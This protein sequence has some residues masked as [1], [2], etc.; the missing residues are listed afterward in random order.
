MEIFLS[1][2]IL[3]EIPFVLIV[4]SLIT[5]IWNTLFLEGLVKYIFNIFLN[6]L[7]KIYIDKFFYMIKLF[8]QNGLYIFLS[9]LFVSM[10]FENQSRN[11]QNFN[12][13]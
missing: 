3:E 4:Y 1:Q 5:L 9:I 7:K 13:L 10:I 6:F 8:L 2:Y 12:I 11:I